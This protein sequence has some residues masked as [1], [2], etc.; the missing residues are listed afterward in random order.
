MFQ[1]KFCVEGNFKYKYNNGFI[2][3][4]DPIA[5][6]RSIEA[7]RVIL[8]PLLWVMQHVVS[9]GGL[10]EL[11]LGLFVAGVAVG[12]IL[13]GY[14][15]VRLLYLVFRG[16]LVNAEHLVVVSLIHSLFFASYSSPGEVGR[17]FTSYCPTATLA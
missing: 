8:L 3:L 15:A 7:E 5:A 12:V 10:L 6:A 14:L 11:R 13:D 4:S 17:G 2:A 1:N 16:L 9:L